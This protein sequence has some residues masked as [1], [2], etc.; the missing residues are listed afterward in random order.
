MALPG[1]V[2]FRIMKVGGCMKALLNTGPRQR[3]W[4]WVAL[5]VLVFTFRLGFGLCSEFWLEDEKQTFLTG[6]KFYATGEW[7]YFGP[8]VDYPN[9][10]QQPGALQGLAVG[11]PLFIFP[12]PEAPFVLLNLLSFFSLAFLAW[13]ATERLPELPKWF[14]WAW[15]MTAPWTLNFSTHVVNLSYLLPGGILF[16]V[17]VIETYPFLSKNLIPLNLAN[18][19]MGLALIWVMQFHMSWVLLPTYVLVSF[20]FQYR[21]RGRNLF[22]TVGWFALGAMLSGSLLLPTLYR[23]GLREGMGGTESTVGFNIDNVL[24]IYNLPEGIIGRFLSFASF[25]LPRF[26]GNNSATRLAFFSQQPWLVPIGI[27][28]L[29]VGILQPIA[30]FALWFLK[31]QDQKDWKAIKYFTLATVCLLYLAF[32]FAKGKPP[33]AHTYYVMLPVAMIYSFYCWSRFLRS[34]GGLTFAKIV[35]VCGLIFHAGLALNNFFTKSLFINR[36]LPASAIAARDYHLLGE[37]RA[38]ARY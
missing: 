21:T 18:F 14:V 32:L 26:L 36:N 28:L 37:R 16:F 17:S 7:P 11:V 23:Y 22:S 24:K 9:P 33:S 25:E 4:Y 12:V 2:L 38:G 15:L 35:I 1:V 27:F 20:Y 30:M 3:R 29:V 6:L 19:L 5:L 13:Y 31:N 8:E 34:R 10:A